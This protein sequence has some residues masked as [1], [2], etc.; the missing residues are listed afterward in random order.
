MYSFIFFFLL[1]IRPPP[2]ST[3]TDT[4]FPY[5]TLFRSFGEAGVFVE[6]AFVLDQG[7][8]GGLGSLRRAFRDD[9]AAFG[10]VDDDVAGAELLGI[11]A[12]AADGD[13]AGMMEAV[14]NGGGAGFDAGDLEF[15]HSVA[16][17][18]DDALE[19]AYPAEA[20]GRS[21]GDAQTG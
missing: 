20:F 3:R 17:A 13:D 9:A 14:T 19:R 5:T 8:A 4:L 16:E 12:R 1:M 21:R 2:R 11:V 7:Q 18:G 6:Q 15:N 10:G